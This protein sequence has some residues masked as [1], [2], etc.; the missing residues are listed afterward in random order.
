MALN[1]WQTV[2]N[3]GNQWQSAL[4]SLLLEMALIQWQSVAIDETHLLESE[5][6]RTRGG[7]QV[8]QVI[9]RPIGAT[10]C[11]FREPTIEDQVASGEA[12]Y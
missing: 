3:S 9:R 11:L 1:Q 4:A 8:R 10:L 7:R 6:R 12:P 2:A 5:R